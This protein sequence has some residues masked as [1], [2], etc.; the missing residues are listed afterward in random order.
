MKI[1]EDTGNQEKTSNAISEYVS[2]IA[3]VTHDIEDVASITP[4][5]HNNYSTRMTTCK[6]NAGIYSEHN[7]D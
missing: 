2:T 4:I 6:H 3:A 5:T 7:L 1:P